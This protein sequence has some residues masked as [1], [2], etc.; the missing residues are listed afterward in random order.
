MYRQVALRSYQPLMDV[1]KQNGVE[2]IIMRSYAN[3]RVLLPDIINA[4]FNCLWACECS[5]EGMDYQELRR[6][7]GSELRLIGGIDIDVLRRGKD[8]IRQEVTKKIPPL[9]EQGGYI[10][11]ADG[12]VREGVSYENYRF[13]RKLLEKVV[14]G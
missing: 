5:P 13:Y 10:P 8:S 6:E 3:I 14:I 4:G 11:L 2:T 1:L 9:L 7:F 12:R